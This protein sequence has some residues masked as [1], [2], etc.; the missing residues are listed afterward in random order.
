MKSILALLFLL[1]FVLLA[2]WMPWADALML[3]VVDWLLGMLIYPRKP[4]EVERLVLPSS[5]DGEMVLPLAA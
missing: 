3:V 5:K 2:S 4:F 1:M